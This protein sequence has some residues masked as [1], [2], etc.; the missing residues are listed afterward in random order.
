MDDAIYNALDP[1][2]APPQITR[3]GAQPPRQPRRR[4]QVR[5]AEPSRQRC[6]HLELPEVR[7]PLP[8]FAAERCP[9]DDVV[10]ERREPLAEVDDGQRGGRRGDGLDE[11]RHLGLPD[12]LHAAHLPRAEQLEHTDLAHLPP[13]LPV[14]REDETPAT[15]ADD[16]G[17]R[18]PRPAGEGGVFRPHHLRGR[19]RGGDDDGGH[20]AE[21]EHH[22]RAV[23]ARQAEQR[24]V[25]RGRADEVVEA[26][27]DGEVPWARG[28][29]GAG[30][31][32]GGQ[33]PPADDE[34]EQWEE[35]RGQSQAA[36]EGELVH[37][38]W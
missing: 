19:L 32:F 14:G 4:E 29:S 37:G 11:A 27:D 18:A 9:A 36:A 22:Q 25:R 21:P 33:R 30:R 3:G 15:E 17:R 35:D 34:Q 16:V 8:A 5:Q 38:S 10:G 1:G 24:A 13:V 6:H 31:F 7:L 12:A 2:V 28:K 20:L 23:P 26:A